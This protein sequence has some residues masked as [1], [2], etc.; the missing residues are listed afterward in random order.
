MKHLYVFYKDAYKWEPVPW[1]VCISLLRQERKTPM[2]RLSFE[3]WLMMAST[4]DLF[5][6][7]CLL[8]GLK[9]AARFWDR[10]FWRIYGRRLT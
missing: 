8:V 2:S 10:V 5:S 4:A 1:V 9:R 6:D 3:F 7:A